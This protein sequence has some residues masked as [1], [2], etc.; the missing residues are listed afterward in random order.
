MNEGK[1]WMLILLRSR[2]RY[3]DRSFVSPKFFTKGNFMSSACHH[4]TNCVLMY[5]FITLPC[6]GVSSPA[7]SMVLKAMSGR[8]RW[9]QDVSAMIRFGQKKH[10]RFGQKHGRFGQEWWT[11]RP[12]NMDVSA[13][14]IFNSFTETNDTHYRKQSFRYVAC[15]L[16]RWQ[17]QAELQKTGTNFAEKSRQQ[18]HHFGRNVHKYLFTH[19]TTK[20]TIGEITNESFVWLPR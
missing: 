7:H 1:C 3:R 9:L 16:L 20:Y 11:F 5:W 2:K 10:G 12:K 6:D 17:Q 13:K 8:S 15:R 19:F 18:Y 14:Y 4:A